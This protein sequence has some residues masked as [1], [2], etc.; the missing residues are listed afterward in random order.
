MD[1]VRDFAKKKGFDAVGEVGSWKGFKVYEAYFDE[2]NEASVIGLPQ[3]VLEK[4]S[5]L[6]F[7]EP[8]ETFDIMDS[9]DIE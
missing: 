8:E 7:C 5:D 9:I 6:R 4:D 3:Y 1:S 2:G